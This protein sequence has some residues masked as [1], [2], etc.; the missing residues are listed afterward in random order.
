MPSSSWPGESGRLYPYEYAPL[1][2]RPLTNA[3]GNY[4]FA[5]R[6]GGVWFAVYVGQGKLRDRYDAAMREGCVARKSA[7]HYHW[8]LNASGPV[9]ELEELDIIRGN[10]ECRAPEGCNERG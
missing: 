2:A 4:V 5:K 6:I 10:T 9:R 1:P 8:H 7:T 3:E